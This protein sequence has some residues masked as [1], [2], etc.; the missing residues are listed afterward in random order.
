MINFTDEKQQKRVEEMRERE[1]E[2]LSQILAQKYKLPYL[3]LSRVTIDLDALKLVPEEDAREAKL[4]VFQKSGK[5]L[6]VAILSPNPD[7]TKKIIKELEEKGFKTTLYMVSETSLERVWKRYSEVPDFVEISRGI[8][9]VSPEKLEEFMGEAKNL[10]GLRSILSEATDSKK[11]RKI[12]EVLE[13]VLAGAIASDASDIHI[14][15]QDGDVRL[16]LRLD[17]VLHDVALLNPKT[18]PLLLSRIKLVSGLKLNVRD[19]AQDGRFSIKLKGSETEVRVSVIPEAYGESIVMRILDPKAISVPLEELGIEDRLY[20]ILIKEIRK[21]NGMLLTTG[22]TGSGKTT[23]LYAF[24]K[25]IHTPE[26]KILTIEDPIEYHLKGI[27]QTQVEKKRGYTFAGG[28]R[29]ALRQD[30]D[31]IM[32]GEIRDL[33]TAKTAM[34]AALT[35]HLVFSTL[36]TNNAA[37]TIPRLIDLGVN[38]SIIAPAINVAMAQRLVRKL[39]PDCKEKAALSEA[40]M[41]K[42]EKIISELPEDF[43]ERPNAKDVQFWKAGKCEKCN[44]TG[45]KGRIGIFEAIL[46]NEK[47]EGL[48]MNNPSET[49]ITE[50]AKSQGI[51]NMQQDGMLKVIRGITSLEELQRVVEL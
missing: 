7:P 48:I 12:S 13:I 1:A 27:I 26:V 6:Q 16:R 4:A 36:H 44:N 38:P 47:I 28:L 46:V 50:A 49:E 14:E 29:A 5:R 9:D 20:S 10:D 22:P 23:A 24:L 51:L 32:V 18:Y 11:S 31:V 21:P 15:P 37:G 33:E 34:N 43:P 40:E 41:Q 39:C 42:V 30:P 45:Y 35:G 8:I 25:K 2:E 17:G 3:D 19:Q